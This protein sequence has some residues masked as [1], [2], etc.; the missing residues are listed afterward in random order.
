MTR[1][2]IDQLNTSADEEAVATNE[3]G[4]GPLA[5]K[6]CEGCIDLAAGAGVEDL[7]LQPHGASSRVHVSQG[8]A[9]HS[10]HWLD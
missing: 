7:D 2:Q 4:I 10:W 6:G 8:S 5:S 9:R 1:R 3:E